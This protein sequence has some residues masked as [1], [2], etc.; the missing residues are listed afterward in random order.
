[1]PLGLKLPTNPIRLQ[2]VEH[3]GFPGCIRVGHDPEH[4][5]FELLRISSVLVI[6][7][8]FADIRLWC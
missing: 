6:Y 3:S 1:M 5:A 7:A 8:I 4:V 2:A